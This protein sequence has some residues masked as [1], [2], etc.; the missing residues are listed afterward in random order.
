[1]EVKTEGER[2]TRGEEREQR[3][4]VR[5]WRQISADLARPSRLPVRRLARAWQSANLPRRRHRPV[6][7]E[8]KADP[9]VACCT[10]ALPAG[11]GVGSRATMRSSSRFAW[12]PCSSL[13]ATAQPTDT[14][15]GEGDEMRGVIFA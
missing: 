7:V 4:P 6:A 3:R 13:Q 11:L 1:M 8:G 14:V 9:R 12:L 2:E 10:V 15:G 5:H